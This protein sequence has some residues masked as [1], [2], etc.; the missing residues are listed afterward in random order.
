MQ[1][2]KEKT[3]FY[4]FSFQVCP[5]FFT[6]L[7]IFISNYAVLQR[8]MEIN[9]EKISFVGFIHELVFYKKANRYQNIHK[10]RHDAKVRVYIQHCSVVHTS[11]EGLYMQ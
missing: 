9:W 4:D 11:L 3:Y 10:L 6:T 5:D 1:N 7:Y 8:L 2:R